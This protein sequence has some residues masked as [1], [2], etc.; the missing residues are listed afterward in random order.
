MCRRPLVTPWLD[1]HPRSYFGC[2]KGRS[3][4]DAVWRAAC[5]SEAAVAFG[6]QAATQLWDMRKFYERFSLQKLLSRGMAV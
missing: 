2:G 3:P 6:G 4:V 1:R 5:R